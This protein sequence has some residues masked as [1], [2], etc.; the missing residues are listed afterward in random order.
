MKLK[1][2]P[3][4]LFCYTIMIMAMLSLAACIEDDDDDEEE[5]NTP[6][7]VQ[8]K[9]DSTADLSVVVLG[10]GGP[11]ATAAGRAS[12]GYLIL[13]EGKPRI[14]MDLGGGT[15]Q[16]LAETEYDLKELDIILLSHLHIDH[17]SD[18]SAAI[19]TIY[20]HNLQAINVANAAGTTAP[21]LRTT[22]IRIFGPDSDVGAFPTTEEYVDGLYSANGIERYIRGFPGLIEAGTFAYEATS[23]ASDEDPTTATATELIS[24]TDARSG[25]VLKVSAI[26]VN[27]GPVPALAFKIEYDTDNIIV[28]TGDTSSNGTGTTD[29]PGTSNLETFASGADLLIYDTAVMDAAIP[30]QA[31]FK[32]LHTTPTRMGQVAKAA[33]VDKLILSHITAATESRIDEVKTLVSNAGFTG[34]IEA[35]DDLSVYNI[36]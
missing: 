18:L 14:L 12:A 15:F 25:K 31:I 30:P 19:K 21:D 24:E 32:T 23:V 27:H 20:F 28:Y 10:S 33:N 22:P 29:A 26:G 34:M 2:K 8:E 36:K 35:A 1:T 7:A 17:T 16:R 6:L 13:V 3:Y 5:N 11:V 4:L 9:I